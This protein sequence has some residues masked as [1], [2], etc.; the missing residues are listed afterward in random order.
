[1]TVPREPISI[2]SLA[3]VIS[4]GAST[5]LTK[6]Y[7]PRVAHWL[8]TL[9]PS[10]S[11]SLL[12]SWTRDGLS[13]IVFTPSDVSRV[14]MMKVGMAFLLLVSAPAVWDHARIKGH[15]VFAAMYDRLLDGTERAGLAEMRADVLSQAS[16]RTLEIGGGTGSTCPDTRPR[17]SR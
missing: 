2:E 13:L 1:M 12:T 8:T 15:R 6:S 9:T 10:C 7:S 4:S 17:S 14:S 16:G 11:T 3:I 5:T